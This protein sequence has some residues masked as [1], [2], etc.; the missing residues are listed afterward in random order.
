MF[1]VREARQDQVSVIGQLAKEV[2]PQTY[3]SILTEDQIAYMMQLLYSEGSLRK[4]ME[5]GHQFILLYEDHLPVGFA[6]YSEIAQDVYKLQK[7]YVLP[8]LQGRGAGKL[9]IDHIVHRVRLAGA[10]T[11]RLNVNRYNKAKAFYEK[12]GFEVR[13]EEDINIGE[14]YYMNDYIMEKPV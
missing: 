6:S 2:W 5:D 14:G 9:L 12:L 4:Q 8:Q 11:L 7:L 10:R 3:A 1:V 13:G